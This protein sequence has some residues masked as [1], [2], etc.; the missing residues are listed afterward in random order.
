MRR[1][2]ILAAII[3]VCFGVS[4]LVKTALRRGKPQVSESTTVSGLPVEPGG[5]YRRI[6]SLAPSITENLYVL[7]MM[8]RVVGVTRYCDYPPEAL[9]KAKVGGYYDPNYEAILALEP[10]L[11]IMLA[12][13]EAPRKHLAELGFNIVVVNHKSIEGILRSIETI[14]DACGAAQKAKAVTGDLRARM[15]RLQEK[16]AGLPHPRV[17]ISVWRNMGSGALEDV[18]ISG[19]EGFYDEMIERLGGVNVYSGR[20]PFPIVSDEGILRMNPDVIIDIVPDLKARGWNPETIAGEWKSVVQVNAVRNH[21]V[22]VFGEDYVAVPGPRFILIME[23]MA[24]AMYPELDW[25]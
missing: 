22:Y 17:M 14:G 13:D 21:R 9:E 10:D 19:K 6:V 20:V 3:I 16:T 2:L 15:K 8:D 5:A 24:R 1:T 11:I 4:F 23:E 18:N 7:G 25:D 12:E